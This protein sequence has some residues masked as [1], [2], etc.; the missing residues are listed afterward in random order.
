MT[1]E[2]YLTDAQGNR[3]GTIRAEGVGS[4]EELAA[5]T[6]MA[7]EF[8]ISPEAAEALERW[9]LRKDCEE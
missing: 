1:Q 5:F 6:R 8:A 2:I 7:T 3:L 9:S 4:V